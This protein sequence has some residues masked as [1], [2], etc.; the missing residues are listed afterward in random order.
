MSRENDNKNNIV[1]QFAIFFRDVDD[2]LTSGTKIEKIITVH[3]VIE[4]V[5][6]LLLY[7]AYDG[8]IFSGRLVWRVDRIA[9]KEGRTGSILS[10]CKSNEAETVL[11]SGIPSEFSLMAG[12]CI[13][14]S[15]GPD[16][17]FPH[18]KKVCTL[19]VFLSLSQ[20]LQIC[21]YLFNLQSAYK[22][23]F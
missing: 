7:D 1:T 20:F 23:L 6:A 16:Y 3:P 19:Q 15:I 22:A 10:H 9:L 13:L 21:Q 11:R 12:D 18:N 2:L 14:P 17:F 5:K 8:W 4:P